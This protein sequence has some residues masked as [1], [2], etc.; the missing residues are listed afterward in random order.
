MKRKMM[1]ALA[2]SI[3]LT[4]NTPAALAIENPE[5]QHVAADSCM[6][7]GKELTEETEVQILRQLEQ[8]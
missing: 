2:T 4:T 8:D 1:I 6:A 7:N 3:L 5:D